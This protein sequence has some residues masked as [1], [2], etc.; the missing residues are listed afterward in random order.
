MRAK[1]NEHYKLLKNVNVSESEYS[2]NPT[3][4]LY[5]ETTKRETTLFWI[6]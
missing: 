6:K 4:D 3:T 1:H 5:S 2:K